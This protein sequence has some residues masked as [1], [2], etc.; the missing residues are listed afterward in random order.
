[1]TEALRHYKTQKEKG[2]SLTETPG[3][4]QNVLVM[5]ERAVYKF[6]NRSDKPEAEPFQDWVADILRTIR[7]EGRYEL[8]SASQ[9]LLTDAETARA[10][11]EAARVAAEKKAQAAEAALI[12]ERE[13]NE[14]LKRRL[15]N[16]HQKG[17]TVYIARN[18]AD[19]ERELYKIGHSK[20]VCK[21]SGQYSTAMPDGVDMV[22]CVK[23]CDANLVERVVQHILDVYR[24]E[25]NREW[26]QG[27]ADLFRRVL[28]A[29][30]SFVDGLTA[31]LDNVTEAKFDERVKK[32]MRRLQHHDEDG[33]DSDSSTVTVN[34]N[35][36]G[37][38]IHVNVTVCP[39]KDFFQK[40]LRRSANS[41]KVLLWTDVFKLYKREYG[42]MRAPALQ[43][44]LTKHGAVWQETSVDGVKFA[45][46][47]GWEL[48]QNQ[49]SDDIPTLQNLL[50]AAEKQ[51]SDAKAALEKAQKANDSLKQPE[52]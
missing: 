2:F 34:T 47:K 8:P 50:A 26:F 35:G 22:H 18:P 21:R 32:V 28:D 38:T 1:M 49:E 33:N 42:D 5:S 46:F 31:S 43:A 36:D 4:K 12:K 25:A 6:V 48:V 41:R 19:R 30:V 29:V 16:K 27:D 14:S 3:G 11:A 45:G 7:L 9:K 13:E 51:A 40:H 23:T 39:V 15:K 20:D 44:E 10:A 17:Q 24:Y 52:E 37:N